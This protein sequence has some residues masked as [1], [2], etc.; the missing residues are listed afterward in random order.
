V[1]IGELYL[2]GGARLK[3]AT[4]GNHVLRTAT[5]SIGGRAK[6][7][8]NDN[9]L[10]VDYDGASPLTQIRDLIVAGRNGGTWNGSGIN[11]SIAASSSGSALGFA[12]ASDL[13]T[14]FPAGIA[15]QN[16]DATSIVVRYT[17]S[18][19]A[20]LDQTVDVADLGKLASNWQQSPRRWSQGDFNFDAAVDVADL[21]LLAT[22]WQSSLSPPTTPARASATSWQ[23][24]RVRVADELFGTPLRL[25]RSG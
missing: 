7:D 8:L 19:D 22:N 10:I 21:S 17:L 13:F 24:A 11:S 20:T 5:L 23:G 16:V 25:A 18:G 12:E 15:G 9:G 6:L 1:S 4:A 2:T 3:L 14:A